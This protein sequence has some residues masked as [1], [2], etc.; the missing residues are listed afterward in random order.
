MQYACPHT[1]QYA[2]PH[3]MQYLC[4]WHQEISIAFDRSMHSKKT[5]RINSWFSIDLPLTFWYILLTVCTTYVNILY[6]N[7]SDK[8]IENQELI[9]R[10]FFAVMERTWIAL[11]MIS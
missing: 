4:T 3:T 6:Q 7:V 9:L 10:V 2:C 8:S 1:M 5:R 11:F